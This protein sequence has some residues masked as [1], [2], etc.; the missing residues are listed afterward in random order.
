VAVGDSVVFEA[1]L[2][3]SQEML[4][5]WRRNGVNMPV[6][7]GVSEKASISLLK[8]Q[9]KDAGRYSLAVTNDFGYVI[10]NDAILTVLQLPVIV[11]PPLG[12][13]AKAGT[14][15]TLSVTASGEG[16]LKYQWLWNRVPIVGAAA[17]TF[18]IS[19]AQPEQ[20]G[21]YT[22]MVSNPDGSVT[23]APVTVNIWRYATT[24][25]KLSARSVSSGKKLIEIESVQEHARYRIMVSPNLVLWSELTNF[26]G[27]EATIEILDTLV[28]EWDQR[29][30]RLISP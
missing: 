8:V 14:D 30:Y 2:T 27:T 29:F 4:G 20:S 21:S 5:I 1:A 6:G 10:S 11:V 12:I 16:T 22:V 9:T 3:G 18:I 26:V 7:G 24:S 19:N 28:P 13:A 25:P 17:S 15:V 23:S